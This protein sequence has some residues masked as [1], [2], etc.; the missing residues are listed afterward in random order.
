MVSG[1]LVL[2]L[3]VGLCG[4]AKLGFEKEETG[5]P[6]SLLGF[7]ENHLLK[8]PCLSGGEGEAF[9]TQ[10]S[11][12]QSQPICHRQDINL[13]SIIILPSMQKHLLLI[14]SNTFSHL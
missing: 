9:N 12:R 14:R 5:D 10:G 11:G 1:L 7:S 2:Y 4:K 8:S 13:R 6:P 3:M